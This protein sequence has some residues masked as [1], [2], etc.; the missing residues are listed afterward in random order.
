MSV[1]I[2]PGHLDL[3][4]FLKWLTPWPNAGQG[5]R[6]DAMCAVP[7]VETSPHE[8][9]TPHQMDPHT[10]RWIGM[11]DRWKTFAVFDR[12]ISHDFSVVMAQAASCLT[13]VRPAFVR[14]RPRPQAIN[15]C[16][17]L[18]SWATSLWATRGSTMMHN[19]AKS[20]AQWQLNLVTLEGLEVLTW[21]HLVLKDTLGLNKHNNTSSKFNFLGSRQTLGQQTPTKTYTRTHVYHIMCP[22]WGIAMVCRTWR[23]WTRPAMSLRALWHAARACHCQW[24]RRPSL[25][26]VCRHPHMS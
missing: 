5:Q 6:R 11:S 9:F 20:I 13:L 22:R 1:R 24:L 19:S 23:R 10:R 18:W 7:R 25:Q 14:S 17:T 2:R 21:Q 8:G 12:L 16:L 15:P 26:R 3:S 4:L